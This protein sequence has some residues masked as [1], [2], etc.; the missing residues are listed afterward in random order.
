MVVDDLDVK[1]TCA[2]PAKADP[3]LIVDTDAVLPLALA[4]QR[5]EPVTRRNS[6]RH[7]TVLARTDVP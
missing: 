4:L 6:N 7:P 1:C 5:F 3:P 2:F